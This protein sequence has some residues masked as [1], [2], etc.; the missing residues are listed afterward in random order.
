MRTEALRTAHP[1]IIPPPMEVDGRLIAE[2]MPHQQEA[3]ESDAR[4]KFPQWGRGGGKTVYGITELVSLA[5]QWPGEIGLVIAQTGPILEKWRIGKLE[6]YLR[7]FEK[8]NG[9]RIE[10]RFRRTPFPRYE[11]ITGGEWWLLPSDHPDKIPGPDYAYGMIEEASTCLNQRAIWEALLPTFRAR[12]EFTLILPTTPRP[13]SYIVQHCL[14]RMREKD[15]DYWSSKEASYVNTFLDP[16]FWGL[17]KKELSLEMYQQ[18]IEADMV[19]VEGA[20]YGRSFLADVCKGDLRGGNI[21]NFDPRKTTKREPSRY[22]LI[23]GVDWGKETSFV[24]IVQDVVA[25]IDIIVDELCL[26]DMTIEMATVAITKRIREYPERLGLDMVQVW[27]DPNGKDWNKSLQRKVPGMCRVRWNW[28]GPTVK[29]AVG[30]EIIQRRLR[31][32]EGNRRLFISKDVVAMPHN[33]SGGRGTFQ[34]LR[35][36]YRYAKFLASGAFRPEPLKDGWFDHFMDAI[37]YPLA[38][39]H[40]KT[41]YQ[42]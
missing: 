10:R 5:H 30:V 41:I 15:P 7:W 22:R 4:F 32:A 26:D 37:R 3:L 31:D 12:P 1:L 27:T 40:L 38:N 39:V 33:A 18:E 11:L 42:P 35:G 16:E 14:E 19:A 20:V 13:D 21:M 2:I 24:A 9:Y 6:P 8:V 23:G 36:G 34:G 25:D 17:M 28:I 29:V